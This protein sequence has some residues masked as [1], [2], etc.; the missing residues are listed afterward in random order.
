M[1][2]S[3]GDVQAP[4]APASILH[5]QVRTTTDTQASISIRPHLAPLFSPFSLASLLPQQPSITCHKGENER[6]RRIARRYSIRLD[7]RCFFFREN[8]IETSQDERQQEAEKKTKIHVCRAAEERK[9]S[10]RGANS[11][12]RV[13]GL[14]VFFFNHPRLLLI[15][16]FNSHSHRHTTTHK[17]E[18]TLTT[19]S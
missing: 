6:A 4:R 7:C 2:L 17:K 15:L 12:K 16:C 14:Y 1:P 13:R 18:N 9:G 8:K 19:S 5:A 10:E 3:E 11:A